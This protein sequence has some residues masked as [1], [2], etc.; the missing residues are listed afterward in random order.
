M[1][2]I[3]LKVRHITLGEGI[4]TEADDKFITVQFSSK[5]SKFVFPDVFE[6]FI[7]AEDDEKQA[8]ILAYI[9]AAKA[10]AEKKRVADE[11]ARQEEEKRRREA[12]NETSPAKRAK[13]LDE[14]FAP[15]Y[16]AE[17]LARQPI[18]TYQQVEEQFGIRV[19]GFGRGINPTE[20]SVVLTSSIDKAA[21]KFVYHDRWTTDGDYIYSGEGKTGDQVMTKGNLAIRDAAKNGKEIHLF[22]K[23][24]PQE[25]YY[26]GVFELADYAYED[27]KDEDGNVRKEYKFHLKKLSK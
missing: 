12:L 6:K 22:V 16:H 21:G 3:G 10:E 2:L 11:A 27:E 19:T 20:R 7:T 4:I 13:S 23:F 9:H 26:Q 15:D 18:L 24:S 17:K 25:Y 8:E 14:M 1:E 5:N